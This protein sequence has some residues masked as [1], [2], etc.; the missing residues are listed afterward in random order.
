MQSLTRSLSVSM[1]IW[2]PLRKVRSKCECVHTARGH[3][4]GC[5]VVC[6]PYI[7]GDKHT[8]VR[9]AIQMPY[10]IYLKKARFARQ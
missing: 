7:Y 9:D 2:F 6:T 10:L 4:I 1:V 3:G 8:S 5:Q